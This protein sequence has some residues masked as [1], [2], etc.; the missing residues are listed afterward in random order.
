M[1]A[2][3]G[4]TVDAWSTGSVAAGVSV[5]WETMFPRGEV[6]APVGPAVVRGATSVATGI[7]SAT[8]SMSLGGTLVVG[9]ATSVARTTV[10]VFAI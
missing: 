4:P 5:A 10:K 1:L 2:V 9:L 8:V 3:E 6:P 7:A